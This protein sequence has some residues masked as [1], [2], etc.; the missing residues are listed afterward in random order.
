VLNLLDLRDLM[1]QGTALVGERLIELLSL[2]CLL[3]A[4]L[5]S[6]VVHTS[7]LRSVAGVTGEEL[8]LS[9]QSDDNGC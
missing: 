3:F 1:L 8:F 9:P 2:E 4:S 6:E 5:L 7:R